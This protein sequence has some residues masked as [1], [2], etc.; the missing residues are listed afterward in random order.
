[1]RKDS[2]VTVDNASIDA[3]QGVEQRTE[4]V[5]G[6][7]LTLKNNSQFV[8]AGLLVTGAGSLLSVKTGSTATANNAE[9]RTGGEISIDNANLNVFDLHAGQWDDHT[10]TLTFSDNAQVNV[11]GRLFSEGTITVDNSTINVVDEIEGTGGSITISQNAQINTDRI[12]LL[13]A[14]VNTQDSAWQLTDGGFFNG[15]GYT[16]IGG[17][18]SFGDEFSFGASSN[19]P[20]TVTLQDGALIQHQDLGTFDNHGNLFVKD[21]STFSL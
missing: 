19:G 20:A 14:T 6:G 5:E 1:V 18:F 8:T 10:G 17:S 15:G 9:A 16:Q 11:G 13:D 7:L 3:T 4:L 21:S 12:E 2:S